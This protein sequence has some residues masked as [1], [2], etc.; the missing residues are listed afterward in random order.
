VYGG[1]VVGA[2]ELMHGKTS[3]VEHQGVGVFES[4]AS[5]VQT[6]RYHS[7][8]VRAEDLPDEL[9]VTAT[10]RD[11]VIMGMRHRSMDVEGVQFHPESILTVGG[12]TMVANFI[13]RCGGKSE[14][15]DTNGTSFRGWHFKAAN[16]TD[17]NGQG[18]DFPWTD[19]DHCF[20]RGKTCRYL[21][22]NEWHFPALDEYEKR[23]Q[24]G[25]DDAALPNAHWLW[26]TTTSSKRRICH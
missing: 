11:G 8:I 18:L 20:M 15:L 13:R 9:E 16:Y 1:T 12:K 3:E 23:K 10:T 21:Q 2:P 17:D 6:T 24:G 19:I 25:L 5:P 4:L 14:I 26:P 7:L 22:S